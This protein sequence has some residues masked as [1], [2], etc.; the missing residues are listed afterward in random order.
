MVFLKPLQSKWLFPSRIDLPYQRACLHL[1]HVKEIWEQAILSYNLP[2]TILL[3]LVVLFWI[4]S[5]LGTIGIDSLDGELDSDGADLSDL[6]AAMLRVVNAGA[7][8]LTVVLSVLVLALWM[9]S[10]TLNYYFNPTHSSFVA[11]ACFL[12]A[13][14]GAVILTKILT[15][16]L[17]PLMR[18]L[19]ESENSQPVI[20]EVG[21]VRS[22][23]IDDRFGQVEVQRADGAP[24]LLNA[25]L[26]IDAEPLPRGASVIVVSLDE[27]TGIYLVRHVPMAPLT[28]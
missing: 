12:G 3:G 16:P 18:K 21:V 28:N 13:L 22:L 14:V 5:L 15:Q 10:L 27:N 23:E 8:P 6:P 20:G 1:A 25:K 17:V 19:K 11:A 9:L 4:F 24:A 2:L 7:V 26:G